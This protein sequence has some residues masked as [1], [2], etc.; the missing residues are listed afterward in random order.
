VFLALH[1]YILEHGFPDS[2]PGMLKAIT[3]GKLSNDM[4]AKI[5]SHA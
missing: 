4:Q 3:K 1:T 2:L 5:A